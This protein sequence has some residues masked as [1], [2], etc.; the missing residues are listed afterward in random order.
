MVSN[1]H[2]GLVGLRAGIPISSKA[3]KVICK[4]DSENKAAKGQAFKVTSVEETKRQ[5]GYQVPYFLTFEQEDSLMEKYI[6]C[7]QC[8]FVRPD[9]EAS[10]RKWMAYECRN[11]DSDSYGSLLN[12]APNGEKQ[13]RITWPGCKCGEAVERSDS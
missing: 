9:R 2:G 1:R 6:A 7:T 13:D 10:E 12:I 5:G 11:P 4:K 8:R 3:I